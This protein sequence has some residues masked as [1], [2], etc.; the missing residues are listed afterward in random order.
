[1]IFKKNYTATTSFVQDIE[2]PEDKNYYMLTVTLTEYYLFGIKVGEVYLD[3]YDKSTFKPEEEEEVE[4]CRIG[5]T[6]QKKEN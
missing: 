5:F 1:M 3:S 2:V 4:E 6:K